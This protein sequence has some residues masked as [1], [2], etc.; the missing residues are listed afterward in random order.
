M[1][2]FQDFYDGFKVFLITNYYFTLGH[3]SS[4]FAKL[5][6]RIGLDGKIDV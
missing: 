2:V 4:K 1:M 6:K 3:I 5:E